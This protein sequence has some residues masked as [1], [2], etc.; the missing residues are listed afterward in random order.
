[1][2]SCP[3]FAVI[4]PTLNAHAEWP[5]LM[6]AIREQSLQPKHL[7]IID[8]SS[9]DDTVKLANADD[10]EVAVIPRGEFNHGLTRQMGVT[11]MADC[12]LVIFLAQDCTLASPD[13]L[14]RLLAPF[15]DPEVGAAYG[16]QLPRPA[17]GPFERHLR[18]FNYGSTSEL[19][20]IADV[21]RLGLKTIFISNSFAAYRRS[22]L[23]EVGGFPGGLIMGEDTYVAAKL[24]LAGYKVSYAAD[25]TAYHSH[26]YTLTQEFRRYFD[27]GVLHARDSWLLERFGGASGTG[28]KYALSEV[29]ALIS[30]QPWRIPESFARNFFKW[31][32]YQ[33]GRKERGI[34]RAWKEHLSMH[35]FYWNTSS[36]LLDASHQS[37]DS[38]QVT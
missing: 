4:I 23:L 35:R 12:D 19:R 6:P 36:K 17:A 18:H 34:P 37:P 22:T 27:I 7:L 28:V 9:D 2:N 32:G 3:S 33:L 11:R 29:Q 21:A 10:C 5:R 26:R 15:Q 8:S 13:S 38:G 30:T 16:R 1:V 25:A 24:L 31:L 20:S 14:A